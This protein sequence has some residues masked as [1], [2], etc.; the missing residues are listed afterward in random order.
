[1]MPAAEIVDA[2]LGGLDLQR[3]VEIGAGGKVVCA[4]RDHDAADLAIAVDRLH[5]GDQF[6]HQFDADGIAS[7]RSVQRDHASRRAFLYEQCLVGAHRGLPSYSLVARPCSMVGSM[8][9]SK[10]RFV[11]V[12]RSYCTQ[13]PASGMRSTRASGR[14]DLMLSMRA[15]IDG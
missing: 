5:R 4:A 12:G 9:S 8:N 7:L 10:T 2:L 11:S 1:A 15:A 13:W 3:L 6:V 14:T